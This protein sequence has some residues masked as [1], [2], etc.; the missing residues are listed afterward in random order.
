[1]LAAERL[2]SLNDGLEASIPVLRLLND[3]MWI[4]TPLYSCMQWRSPSV[5]DGTKSPIYWSMPSRTQA[6]EKWEIVRG[7]AMPR[8][9]REPRKRVLVAACTVINSLYSP[10][11]KVFDT[12]IAL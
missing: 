3:T 8:L 7:Q 10:V 9:I 1:M 6:I 11:K 12:L 5:T 2:Q 4:F